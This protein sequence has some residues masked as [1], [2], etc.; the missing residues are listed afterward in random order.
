MQ[1]THVHTCSHV[2]ACC[3]A[4][5]GILHL[6]TQGLAQF[7][8]NTI[9]FV[10]A[11]GRMFEAVEK[12]SDEEEGSGNAGGDTKQV[13]KRPSA[14]SSSA[15]PTPP[16]EKPKAKP[17]EKGK[18][19]PKRKVA[20]KEPS[21]KGS[22]KKKSKEEEEDHKETPDDKTKAPPEE[23][24]CSLRSHEASRYL[25]RKPASQCAQIPV[26]RWNLCLQAV[27]HYQRVP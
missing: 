1:P 19:T 10:V 2:L 18:A 9:M 25:L 8:G 24:C 13:R 21:V 12:L 4:I 15:K 27:H 6:A 26:Q 5:V 17:K 23:T 3:H 22:P 16:K 14:R 7:C 20:S 11:V